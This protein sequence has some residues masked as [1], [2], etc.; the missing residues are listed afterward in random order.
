MPNG[1]DVL[2]GSDAGKSRFW[3]VDTAK[4]L[5]APL[6]V[7]AWILAARFDHVAD[8][9]ITASEE[10]ALQRRNTPLPL[11]ADCG[12]IAFQIQAMTGLKL[13]AGGGIEVLD[14]MAWQDALNSPHG[15]ADAPPSQRP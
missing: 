14:R 12:T 6:A 8:E 5:G 15:V 13:Q 7:N 4:P 11:A 9:L 10:V 1:R 3:G 2:I